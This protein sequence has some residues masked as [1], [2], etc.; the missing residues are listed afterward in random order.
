MIIQC[1]K[2][3]AAFSN[4]VNGVHSS[5]LRQ[6][7]TSAGIRCAT[8]MRVASKGGAVGRLAKFHLLAAYGCDVGA[9]ARIGP[10]LLL[11]HP[12]G[13]V[14]GMG[15]I[16]ES[17]AHIFQGVTL[18]ANGRG[19]YP[20]IGANV[21]FYPGSMVTGGVCVGSGA[22]IGAGAL[23]YDDVA[24]GEVVRGPSAVTSSTE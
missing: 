18:G 5:V 19:E 8:W 15:T 9:G 20:L 3:D 13:I 6:W 7:V 10:G 11:S 23:V 1:L 12:T 17:R 16:I 22:R 14:I 21:I 4:E 24:A 2:A